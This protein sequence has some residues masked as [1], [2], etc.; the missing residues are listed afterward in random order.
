MS[1]KRKSKLVNILDGIPADEVA[2]ALAQDVKVAGIL[3]RV[4]TEP[5][6]SQVNPNSARRSAQFMDEMRLGSERALARRIESKELFSKEELVAML[7]GKRRRV[8]DALRAGC[9]FS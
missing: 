4:R 8:N 5:K 1:T 9:L 3:R 6:E 7:G 2:A